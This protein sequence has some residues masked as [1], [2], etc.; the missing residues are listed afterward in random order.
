[1]PA[2]TSSC[3]AQLRLAI[4][5]ENLASQ[6]E[7]LKLIE[8]R[9]QAGFVTSLDVSRQAA[10]VAT[11]AASVPTLQTAASANIHALGILLG[12][13]PA[14]LTSE[15]FTTAPIPPNPPDV[16][17]GI[18]A[19]LLRRR[20]DIR[21]A[22][23]QLAAATARVGVATADL[24]PRL[25]LSGSLSLQGDTIGHLSSYDSLAFSFGPSLT[26]PVFDAGKIR[27]NIAVEDERH[28]PVAVRLPADRRKRVARC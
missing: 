13:D 20:P 25:V 4:A 26:W 28:A 18:P 14:A 3:A 22:E 7:T 27:A 6:R 2:T 10:L 12:Q 15:L 23:R 16:P 24:Y 19:D 1:M 9:N 21:R 8:N 17:T 5:K 11:T